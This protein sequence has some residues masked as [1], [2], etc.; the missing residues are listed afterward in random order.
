VT[1]DRDGYDKAEYV[2]EENI[3]E[4]MWTSSRTR[5]TANYV[6]IKRYCESYVKI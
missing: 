3:N 5:S 2:S 4:D 1:F 6:Q